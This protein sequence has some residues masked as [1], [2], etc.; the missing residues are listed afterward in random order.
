MP[1]IGVPED[2]CFYIEG[3]HSFCGECPIYNQK[4]PLPRILKKINDLNLDISELGREE[5]RKRICHDNKAS[6]ECKLGKI[7]DE[8][9]DDLYLFR[10]FGE[11]STK[12]MN[13]D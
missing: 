3:K 11:R 13:M 12:H 4:E 2:G 1:E 8:L 9:N 7:M 10:R 5:Y 6:R